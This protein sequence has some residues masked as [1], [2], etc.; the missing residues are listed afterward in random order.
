MDLPDIASVI[1]W[2]FKINGDGGG[3]AHYYIK[4]FHKCLDEFRS[5]FEL[6]LCDTTIVKPW[7]GD[8]WRIE[9]EIEATVILF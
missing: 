9:K 6:N 4:R 3:G 1:D 7:F 5:H 8:H 2:L